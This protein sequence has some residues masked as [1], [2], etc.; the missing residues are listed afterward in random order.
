MTKTIGLFFIAISITF[1]C[2]SAEETRL[3]EVRQILENLQINPSDTCLDE[4]LQQRGRII[5]QMSFGAAGGAGVIGAST[6]VAASG[7]ATT[8]TTASTG[9]AAASTL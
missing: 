1:N 4:Y 7:I 2:F 8:T 5:R 9:A 3:R 6:A